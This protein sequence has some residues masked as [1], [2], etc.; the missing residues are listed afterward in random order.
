MATTAS[1]PILEM[2]STGSP[3]DA[4]KRSHPE[5]TA[6]ISDAELSHCR[7]IDADNPIVSLKHTDSGNA[8]FR[9]V[10]GDVAKTRRDSRNATFK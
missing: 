7:T 3:K 2:V 8:T 4:I 5:N 10:Y 1:A 9:P 6:N